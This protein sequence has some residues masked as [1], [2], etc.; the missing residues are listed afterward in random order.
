MI[1][2]N[3]ALRCHTTFFLIRRKCLKIIVKTFIDIFYFPTL[4]VVPFFAHFRSEN[5]VAL[6]LK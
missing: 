5:K 1:I 4:K 3:K 6:I 2:Q